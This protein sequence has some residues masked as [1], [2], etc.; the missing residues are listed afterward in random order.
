MSDSGGNDIAGGFSRV[1]SV[2]FV[3]QEFIC[4]VGGSVDIIAGII[5]HF[6]PGVLKKTDGFFSSSTTPYTG[7]ATS[8]IFLRLMMLDLE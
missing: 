6:P 1:D 7:E 3:S 5:D 2:I 4:S 8:Q